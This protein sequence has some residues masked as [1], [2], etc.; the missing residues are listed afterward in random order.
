MKNL[1]KT[2]PVDLHI[3]HDK[4]IIF[5]FLKQN[6]GLQIYSIGDLDNFFWPKTIWFALNQNETINAIALLYVGMEPSTLL[7]FYDEESYYSSQLLEKIKSILP[8]KLNM[9]LSPD[10]INIFGKENIIE[11]YGF[12]Y[13]MLLNKEV[14]EINDKN[15]RKLT[16]DDL[17]IIKNFYEISYPQNWFDE[18][19]LQ[20]NKYYGYFS[21]NKLIGISG[22]HVYSEEYKVA[23][24][25]N[26]AT[27]PDFRGQ[28]IGYKLT[29]A[30]CFD[31]QKT[32]DSIGLNVK[33]DNEYAIKCYKK[34]GFEIVG[35]F[36]EYF[37]KNS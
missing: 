31:L 29:S 2:K 1:T 36:G 4:S 27:H 34:I 37:V 20:T 18:R 10:L 26:I 28:Q 13:K 9:H 15:I 5:D 8:N 14:N 35:E 19:M 3:L 25:G 22:I 23:A 32:V 12:N 17:Q 33:S 21:K 16:I 7:S 30:L 24:L 6:S 11:H